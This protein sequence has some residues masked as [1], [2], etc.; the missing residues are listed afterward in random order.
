MHYNHLLGKEHVTFGQ[1]LDFLSCGRGNR[2]VHQEKQWK[3]DEK[4][5]DHLEMAR[6]PD[7]NK[8]PGF[9]GVSNGQ[10]DIL[11]KSVSQVP[12]T[13]QSREHFLAESSRNTCARK[14]K[15]G[16]VLLWLMANNTH[17]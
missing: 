13:Y 14:L 15:F 3:S 12:A 1:G 11:Q 2:R 10:V 4:G 7:N 5:E 9:P 6:H 17:M 8:F 16:G